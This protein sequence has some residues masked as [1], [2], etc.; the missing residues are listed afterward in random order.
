MSKNKII[1]VAVAIVLLVGA[2]AYGV[3][4]TPHTDTAYIETTSQ[5]TTEYAT[6]QS[7]EQSTELVTETATELTTEALTESVTEITTA[8]EVVTELTTVK[9]SVE[10]VTEQTT[11]AVSTVH[12]SVN[13]KTLVGKY[14][15]ATQNGG[16]IYEGDYT[17]NGGES[18]FDVLQSCMRTAG[19]PM[20]FSKTPAYNSI[21]VEGIDNIYEFDFGDLSGWM[22]NVNGVF[23]GYASSEYKLQAG[24]KIEFTYT[25]D[26]GKDVGAGY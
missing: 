23:P 13:C 4:S 21:Y 20:E 9:L 3:I 22:Y 10:P 11:K 14:D 17:L 25:C 6:E 7:T 2:F 5:T 12:L 19:I 16:I 8:L 1:F 15:K 24:D 26:L 18:A